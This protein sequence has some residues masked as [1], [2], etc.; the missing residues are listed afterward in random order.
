MAQQ[1]TLNIILFFSLLTCSL[2]AQTTPFWQFAWARIPTWGVYSITFHPSGKAY[3]SVIDRSLI[4]STDFG[5]TWPIGHPATMDAMY[6]LSLT[7]DPS[8][9][10]YAELN[11][12]K[13]DQDGTYIKVGRSTDDGVT[14]SYIAK[15]LTDTT[16]M[17]KVLYA[18]PNG[19]VYLS[20]ERPG[21]YRS[22]DA[23]VSWVPDMEFSARIVEGVLVTPDDEIYVAWNRTLPPGSPLARVGLSHSTDHGAHWTTLGST[24]FDQIITRIIV[25]APNGNLFVGGDGGVY[26]STDRGVSW[27]ATPWRYSVRKLLVTDSGTIFG[28]DYYNVIVTSTDDGISW[29]AIRQEPVQLSAVLTIGLSPDDHLFAGGYLGIMISTDK[30]SGIDA[31]EV[32]LSTPTLT[33]IPNPITD[34]A[35]VTFT[36][37]SSSI[38]H[39]SLINALGNE[40]R[41]LKN[42]YIPAGQQRLQIDLA[43][44]SSGV[45]FCRVQAG[46][47][48]E[49]TL[50]QVIR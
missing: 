28:L 19:D 7:C 15:G 32:P 27:S 37:P 12:G 25:K 35:A 30:T 45:Y 29:D 14:W 22:T 26:R 41:T 16:K 48:M 4:E 1:F 31:T 10:L 8:G 21:L 34:Q 43:G 36:L 11:H 20:S 39:I 46:S 23:G 47:F 44:L 13:A 42:E 2:S 5:H 40:V 17:L 50:V 24:P 6:F 38:A 49:T 9:N 18:A 33:V 3:A